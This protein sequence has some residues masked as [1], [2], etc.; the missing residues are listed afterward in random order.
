[1]DAQPITAVMA[2]NGMLTRDQLAR[3]I[4]VEPRT[5]LAWERDGMPTVKQ[6]KSVFYHVPSVVKWMLKRGTKK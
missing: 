4:S 3:E 1:M 2:A 5:L 6:G